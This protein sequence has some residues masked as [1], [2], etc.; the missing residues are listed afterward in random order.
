[1]SIE[2]SDSSRKVRWALVALFLLGELALVIWGIKGSIIPTEIRE[3]EGYSEWSDEVVAAAATIPVQ[4]GGR[5][6]PLSTLARFQMLGLHGSLKMKIKSGDR[7]ISIGPTEWMLDCLFRPEIAHELPVFRVDDSEVLHRFGIFPKDR[8]ARL[9]YNDFNRDYEKGAGP[10]GGARLVAAAREMFKKEQE[11]EDRKSRLTPQQVKDEEYSR[12]EDEIEEA[13]KYEREGK[14][15]KELAQQLQNYQFLTGFLDFARVE[16][17]PPEMP[18]SVFGEDNLD[19]NRFSTWVSRFDRLRLIYQLGQQQGLEVPQEIVTLLG[20]VEENVNRTR[21][22]VKWLPPRNEDETWLSIGEQIVE[23][24]ENRDFDWQNLRA[25]MATVS[26]LKANE[27]EIPEELKAVASWQNVLIDMRSLEDLV[28]TSSKPNSSEFLKAMA[29]WNDEITSRATVRGEG[30][31]I[32]GEVSYYKR[33]YFM[34]ALVMFLIA[35][36]ISAFG[37]MVTGGK[38]AVGIRW[39]S[40][41]FYV[42]G[43]LYLTGGIVH[44]SILMDRPPVGNLYDTI[45]F[46]T[47]GATLVLGVA[48]WLT[49]RNLLLS[50]GSLLGVAGLFLAFRYEV[51]DANDHMD[52]LVAVLKSNYWL[53]THVVTVTIGYSGGLMACLLSTVFVH[54]RL[55]GLSSGDKSFQRFMT[56]SVYGIF[57][58]TL[59]FSLVGTVLGGIWAND[60]WGRFWGWDPKENGALLIV[61]WC[62]IVLHARLAGWLKDWGLHLCAIFGGAIVGFSWWHVNMLEVGL[63]SYGFIKGGEVIW[64]FYT[65]C[66]IAFLIGIA[67]WALER[68]QKEQKKL[69]KA[70]KKEAVE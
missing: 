55:A 44:R 40:I 70:L 65:A 54:M 22:G 49:R 8:R 37:W 43:F 50:L 58:F 13:E 36:V 16:F 9:S 47:M 23:V 15:I 52:P 67:A 26:E 59:L 53:A 5:V 21:G 45:P 11:E 25:N 34:N 29:S 6:K 24:L 30:E 33:N 27:A 42:G 10:G 17:T 19:P 66:G 51:G 48:E 63:H 62:L 18:E 60:S 39:S 38:W 41:L 69:Q 57:C 31:D 56:R 7:K 20:V 64:L 1:M 2:K 68:H 3:V 61:L 14:I 28:A 35:F 46:I 32:P 12:T 4:D